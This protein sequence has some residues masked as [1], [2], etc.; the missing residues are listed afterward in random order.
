MESAKAFSKSANEKL[1]ECEGKKQ[2]GKGEDPKP[3]EKPKDEKPK[4]V[5]TFYQAKSPVELCASKLSQTLEELGETKVAKEEAEEELVACRGAISECGPER[6]QLKMMNQGLRMVL[7]QSEPKYRAEIAQLK[8][9]VHDCHIQLA[10][11]HN[12]KYC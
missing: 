1:E 5:P 6:E 7:D 9:D 8:D 4:P 11:T 2:E 10:V 3:V 12:G